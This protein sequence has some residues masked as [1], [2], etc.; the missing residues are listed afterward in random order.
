MSQYFAKFPRVRYDLNKTK[1]TSQDSVTNIFFRLAIVREIMTNLSS[2][3]EYSIRDGDR[4]ETLAEKAYGNAEAH[5]II[6][7]ANNILDPHYD[8]PMDNRTFEK[9]IVR[10]YRS[11]ARMDGVRNVTSWAKT[12]Y[13]KYEKVIERT[14]AFTDTSYISR[15][16]ID[17]ANVASVLAITDPY[18]T[19]NSLAVTSFDTFDVSGR[20]ITETIKAERISYYDYEIRENE[21]KRDIKIIKKEYYGRI[22]EQFN[23][24][25][26]AAGART[27]FI[28]RFT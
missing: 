21:K 26:D 9:Y 17:E 13:I 2:Y 14:N 28:R 4:P 11:Q 22:I 23:S 1:I 5:W 3:Y 10:K 25:T 19:Y 18:D 6:L 15:Y 24:L 27:T 7:Y 20:S 12:N 16:E 8:W